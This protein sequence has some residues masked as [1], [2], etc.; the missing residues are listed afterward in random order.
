MNTQKLAFIL[1]LLITI[2]SFNVW[3]QEIDDEPDPFDIP[4]TDSPIQ[5]DE[6]P[7]DL[8]EDYRED[9]LGDER[10]N[11]KEK[12]EK[13]YIKGKATVVDGDTI[14]INNTKIRFSGIDAPES[15]F[16]GMTQYCEKPNGKIWACGKKATAALKKL[17]GK[18]E[19]E[20]SDEG[21]DKYGRTLSIC[22]ANGVD[23][24]SEMVRSGMA[25]AYIRYSTRYENE[26]IEAMTNRAGIWSGDFLDP[27]DWRRQNRKRD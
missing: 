19:V 27:E 13:I 1:P 7:M 8:E 24:Q 14:T 12:K 16:Y 22:Y 11:K 18:N 6:I 10:T 21:N 5:S 23:L 2:Y 15:Y 25:V 26:M 17:I 4:I 3:A 20:C 9:T